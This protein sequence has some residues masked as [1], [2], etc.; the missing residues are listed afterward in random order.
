MSTFR[1]RTHGHYSTI[2][3]K[4]Y[5]I[6]VEKMGDGIYYFIYVKWFGL[7]EFFLERWN[8]PES[9]ILRLNELTKKC[10]R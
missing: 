5:F 4:K 10:I 1:K 2:P 3:M 6:K 9:A 8:S 7:F